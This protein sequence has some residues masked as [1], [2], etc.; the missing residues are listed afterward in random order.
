MLDQSFSA[1]NFR[2]ILDYENRKGVYLEGEYF[3][4]IG[5]VTE[6]I[7]KCNTE[8]REKKHKV[9][10]EAFEIFRKEIKQE[11]RKA[12]RKKRRTANN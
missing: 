1:E 8:V 2:K 9:S 11:E 5:K 6:E 10:E 3:P 7:K 12:E 4:D